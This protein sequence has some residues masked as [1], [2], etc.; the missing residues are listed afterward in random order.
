MA[1]AKEVKKAETVVLENKALINEALGLLS[2]S[3]SRAKAR[4]KN[5][6]IL[7]EMDMELDKLAEIRRAVN[8][9]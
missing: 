9:L 8:T 7:R 5:P 6:V 1:D 4:V 2:Q 3:R